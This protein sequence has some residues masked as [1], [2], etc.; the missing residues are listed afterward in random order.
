MSLSTFHIV[1]MCSL[2]PAYSSIRHGS[3]FVSTVFLG[4]KVSLCVRGSEI[5]DIEFLSVPRDIIQDR[6]WTEIIC[7]GHGAKNLR[8]LFHFSPE[9][10]IIGADNPDSGFSGAILLV[11]VGASRFYYKLHQFEVM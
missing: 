9:L 1:N 5:R 8:P 6:T 11:L 10:R 3:V 7:G 2:D 4:H